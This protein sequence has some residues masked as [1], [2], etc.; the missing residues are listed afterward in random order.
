[1]TE[2]NRIRGIS[3]VCVFN[4]AEVRKDCLDRSIDAYGGPVPVDYIPVDNTAHDFRSAGAALNHGAA[5]ARHEVV[6]FVHQDVFLHSL[7]RIAQAAALLDGDEWGV[8]GANGVTDRGVSVGRI[9]DRVQLIGENSPHPGDVASLDEVLFMVRKDR[10]LKHPLTE[11]P[12]LAWHAYAVE[13]GLR[14]RSQRLRVGALNLAV[15][16]NSLTINLDKL[17]VA[18]RRVAQLHP[19]HLPV[20]TTCGRIG[21]VPPRWR[22]VGVLRDNGWRLR[23][24]RESRIAR[25]LYRRLPVPVFLADIRHDVDLLD[26]SDAAPLHLFNLDQA[27][28]FAEYEV[29][30]LRLMRRDRPL[31]CRSSR[32]RDDLFSW[33][34]EVPPSASWLVTDIGLDDLGCLNDRADLDACIAGVARTGIWLAGGT[35]TRSLPAEWTDPRALPPRALVPARASAVHT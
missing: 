9:R 26:Y 31:I 5:R 32:H 2:P 12:D 19:D 33:L 7:D 4:N 13:F 10:V 18:H 28:G 21:H 24:L 27:G 23:W 14:M 11:D 8:L 6:V 17:D 16:H 29:R 30:L 35:V 22:N 15:T 1:M 25:Q 34:D 20:T 3:I